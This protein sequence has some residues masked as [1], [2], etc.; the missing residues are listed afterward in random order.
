LVAGGY[1]S[2]IEVFHTLALVNGKFAKA[3]AEE[4]SKVAAG[5]MERLKIKKLER[6]MHTH[7]SIFMS[8]CIYFYTL[9][10]VWVYRF[11]YNSM[12]INMYVRLYVSA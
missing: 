2:F 6:E 8:I 1:Y 7:I 12:A 3:I 9:E 10:C 4:C 11:F 5:K